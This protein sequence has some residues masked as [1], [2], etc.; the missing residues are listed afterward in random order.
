MGSHNLT[1]F[2]SLLKQIEEL[3]EEV[4]FEIF[5][6]IGCDDEEL[7]EESL[8]HYVQ[9]AFKISNEKH[10]E[11]MRVARNKEPPEICLNVEVIEAK[12]LEPKDSNG[13]SDPFVT[14]YIASN[15][16]HRY[17]TSVKSA[18]LDPVW[19]EHFSL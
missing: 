1:T 13:L 9:D 3:Y 19:E 6:N 10:E 5:N 8:V 14:M 15:P 2:S 4:L 11:I 17:N 12:E 7:T 18:T 16:T